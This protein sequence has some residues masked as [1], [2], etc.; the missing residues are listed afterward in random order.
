MGTRR[1]LLWSKRLTM[2]KTQNLYEKLRAEHKLWTIGKSPRVLK[3]SC[4]YLEDI[5]NGNRVT[6]HTTAYEY[7][8]TDYSIRKY[9]FQIAKMLA[10][11]KTWQ[12]L[13]DKAVAST[14][15]VPHSNR[16]FRVKNGKG[17]T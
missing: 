2:L 11:A 15:F 8:T 4:K 9:Y 10:L 6:Q 3:A 14:Y 1:P 12:E 13:F 5:L 16:T 7:N 17:E